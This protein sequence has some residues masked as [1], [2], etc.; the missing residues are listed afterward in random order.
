MKIYFIC[1]VSAQ[2][3]YL[4]KFSFVRFGL[5]CPQPISLQDFLIDRISKKNAGG[6]L[7]SCMLRQISIS[8]K[9]I[10]KFWGEHVQNLETLSQKWIDGMN[11]FFACWCNFRKAKSYFSNFWMSMVKN[12]HDYLVHETL[13]EMSLWIELLFC[14]LTVM[15]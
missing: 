8:K 14:M 4:G 10:K 13:K 11:L 15:Q 7:I 5:K 6:N 12:G 3:Q 1:C 2:I 9:L